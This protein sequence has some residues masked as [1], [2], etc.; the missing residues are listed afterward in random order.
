MADGFGFE[1]PYEGKSNDWITPP[2]LVRRLGRQFDLDPCA[3]T[4]QP[5]P[6]AKFQYAPPQ[7]GLILPWT[8]RIFCNPPYGPHIAEWAERMAK[9]GNGIMLVFA[10]TDTEAWSKIWRTGD[11]FLFLTGRIS[12]FLPNGERAGSGTAPSVLIAYGLYN[13]KALYNSGLA[14]AFF[15]RA[16][17]LYGIKAPA[18]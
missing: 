4:Q 3:S 8:G 18:L 9:H 2:E 6:L 17:V 13:I 15:G 14:G 1:K 11:A 16:E 5:W 10:R 7:D 12:F